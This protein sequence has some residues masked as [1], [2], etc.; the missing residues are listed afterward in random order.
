MCL[1]WLQNSEKQDFVAL[2]GL[3]AGTCSCELSYVKKNAHSIAVKSPGSVQSIKNKNLFQVTEQ[4][5]D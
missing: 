2:N 3:L 4:G 1:N 5:I